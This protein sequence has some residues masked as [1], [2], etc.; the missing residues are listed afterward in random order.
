M[1]GKGELVTER[2]IKILILYRKV[3][4]ARL[5]FLPLEPLPGR[6]NRLLYAIIGDDAYPSSYRTIK[7]SPSEHKE[8]SKSSY[9]NYSLSWI[10]RA[11]ENT[12]EIIAS[13]SRVVRKP[14]LLNP[15]K[16]AKPPRYKWSVVAATDMKKFSKTH[17]RCKKN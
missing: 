6:K 15:D 13:V 12:C 16:L 2:F 1:A 10:R 8:G 17:H 7:P 3:I 11:V 5:N 14:I 9:F 4:S